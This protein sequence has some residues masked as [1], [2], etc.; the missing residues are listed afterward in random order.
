VSFQTVEVDRD[1][2][3]VFVIAVVAFVLMVVVVVTVVVVVVVVAVAVVV[4]LQRDDKA[5]QIQREDT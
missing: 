2:E 1:I 5:T 4:A 3:P